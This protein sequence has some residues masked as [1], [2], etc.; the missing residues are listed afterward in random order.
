[1]VLQYFLRPHAHIERQ[2]HPDAVLTHDKQ[3]FPDT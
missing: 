1:M 3:V 2:E